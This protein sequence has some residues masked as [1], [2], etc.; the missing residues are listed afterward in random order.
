MTFS[1]LILTLIIL[2]PLLG[3]L[4]LFFVDSLSFKKNR[5]I[6][7]IFCFLGLLEIIWLACH[8]DPSGDYLQF[9]CK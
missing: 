1:S 7:Q 4:A 3:A 2:T 6:A 5:N 8:F 9:V